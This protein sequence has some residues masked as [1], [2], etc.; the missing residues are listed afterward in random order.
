[1][2][3]VSLHQFLVLYVW[4]PLAALLLFVLLIARF[5]Q[6]FSGAR[7]YYWLYV[8]PL[9]GLGAAAVRYASIDTVADDALAAVLSGISGIVLIGLSLHIYRQ[10]LRQKHP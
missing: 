9:V 8:L 7:I 10:M 6:K 3:S 5:Y 2:S 1:V 4:F